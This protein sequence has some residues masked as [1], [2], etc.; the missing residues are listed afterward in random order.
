MTATLTPQSFNEEAVEYN[1]QA[2]LSALTDLIA[3]AYLAE[4]AAERGACLTALKHGEEVIQAAVNTVFHI[5]DLRER[6]QS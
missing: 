1:R 4:T 2:L 6:D 3:L 5:H